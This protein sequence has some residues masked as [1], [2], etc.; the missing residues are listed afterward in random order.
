MS[1]LGYV[2]GYFI[3]FISIIVIIV[4]LP[5]LNNLV[6]I[7]LERK[8]NYKEKNKRKKEEEEEENEENDN[9]RGISSSSMSSIQRGYVPP[10]A[11]YLES[12]Y[13]DDPNSDGAAKNRLKKIT[14]NINQFRQ[15]M[16]I[17][18]EDVGL[19]F[20]PRLEDGEEQNS[21]LRKRG[22]GL[23]GSKNHKDVQ[24]VKEYY[25][26]EKKNLNPDLY[27]YDLDELINDE[28]EDEEIERLQEYEKQIGEDTV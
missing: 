2:L 13:E 8:P 24:S 10:N 4:V 7:K 16:E 9:S 1:T 11:K 21:R 23:G 18:R 5:K 14:K 19:K 20:K 25:N 15:R 3:F 22:K 28:L 17:K 6:E 27:D 26:N 12:T